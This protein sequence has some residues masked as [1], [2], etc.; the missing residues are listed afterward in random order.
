MKL[1]IQ[2]P[3]YNEEATIGRTLADLPRRIDG[4]SSIAILV[5]DDGSTDKTVEAARRGGANYVVRLLNHRGLS[6]A[7][8]A[9]VD[10]A[11]KLGAD[12]IVNTDA[13]NQ[14]R[15]ADIARLVAPIARGSAEVVI[16]DRDV[17]NSPHMGPGKKFL[18][19]F[20]S[21]A[22]G[23][24]A[25]VRVPDVTSGFRAFS[26]EA[27]YQINVFN[28]F[29]YTLETVIQAGNRNLGV[30]SVQVGTNPPTRPSR[31][32][33]GIGRYVWK[34]IFTIFRIYTVYRP[35]KTFVAIGSI[36]FL[37]GVALGIRFLYYF[38]TGEPGGHIQS[39]ILAAVLLIIGFQTAL[40]GLVADL[41]AV[42]RRLSEDVLVR[43]KKM[44]PR[45]DRARHREHR[46]TERH[47]Q[48]RSE[49]PREPEPQWV[50]LLDEAKLEGRGGVTPEPEPA[51]IPA[52][53]AGTLQARRRRRRRRF[54]P[55]REQEPAVPES[56]PGP[57]LDEEQ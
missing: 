36:L 12:I 42:N 29:T 38:F 55:R 31:L 2:V 37:V 18:Q 28:P 1:I 9:G 44:E 51:A 35:L 13:D 39:L 33:D 27:A 21:W 17:R 43:L 11:L 57:D 26:R 34:S 48:P 22:V 47:P 46:P 54:R 19:R 10:A 49:E 15:G 4:I 32:Y 7:F 53:D 8:V 40:I 24:A 3:A 14:Y 50:W 20:G 45:S 16:G 41:I 23:K 6:T 56:T 5:I 52:S 30:Q 25:G